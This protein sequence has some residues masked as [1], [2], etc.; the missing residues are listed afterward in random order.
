MREEFWFPFYIEKWRS[1]V[2]RLTPPQRIVYLEVLLD[3]YEAGCPVK[4]EMSALALACGMSVKQASAAFE[5]LLA[6]DKLKKTAD[7][8][9]SNDR[10]LEEVKKRSKKRL[11]SSGNGKKG[12][13]PKKPNK[14]KQPKTQQVSVGFEN[15]KLNESQ[16]KPSTSTSTD[17]KKEKEDSC[18]KPASG[19]SDQSRVSLFPET[20]ISEPM[21]QKRAPRKR[22]AYSPSFEA[23][24]KAYPTDPGM[25]KQD[26]GVEYERLPAQD[27]QAATAAIPAFKAW[28]D[29]QGSTYRIIHAVNY[30]IKRR[31]DGFVATSANNRDRAAW[32]RIANAVDQPHKW[33]E[34]E[35]GT[36]PG[37]EGC[38]MPTDL[39][40]AVLR[41]WK[42]AA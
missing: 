24:W 37:R 7:G 17:T 39:Q 21:A 8:R 22:L 31:F 9:F 19:P 18:P 14:I 20:P 11:A 42:A 33:S 32:E 6:L 13:R 2:T 4:V 10:A 36:P 25:S 34:S 16:K 26:A 30:L 41:R 38:Q 12:G 23:F 15:E 29:K 27:Q 3:L 1:G 5:Q 40:Q 28:C 35:W